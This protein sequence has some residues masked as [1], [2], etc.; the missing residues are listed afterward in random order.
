MDVIQPTPEAPL[1]EIVLLICAGVAVTLVMLI[2]Y[3]RNE[4]KTPPTSDSRV[5][6]APDGHPCSASGCELQALV[7]GGWCQKHWQH[8]RLGRPAGWSE[9]DRE[10]QARWEAEESEARKRRAEEERAA[11]EQ[12]RLQTERKRAEEERA[13]REQA[14]RETEF[15]EQQRQQEPAVGGQEVKSEDGDEAQ[16]AVGFFLETI[17]DILQP[18]LH[19]LM[20]LGARTQSTPRRPVAHARQSIIDAYEQFDSGHRDDARKQLENAIVHADSGSILPD[21][22]EWPID[23]TDVGRAHACMWGAIARVFAHKQSSHWEGTD[24]TKSDAWFGMATI[25]FV[26]NSEMVMAGR[27]LQEW[28]ESRRLL[29]DSFALTLFLNATNIFNM[30]NETN[31]AK[32]AFERMRTNTPVSQE[33]SF[34]LGQPPTRGEQ[35]RLTSV[36]GAYNA[37]RF[38]NALR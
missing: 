10:Q 37:A 25:L 7:V 14:V 21:A 15:R 3:R 8:V 34:L 23:G 18:N 35:D 32:L 11:K 16:I 9:M 30:A 6:D 12:A 1:Y 17:R 19:A 13:A 20:E 24:S 5:K 33:S 2:L 36:L 38:Y 22:A 29:G 26:E 31:R 28:G 27:T 4:K